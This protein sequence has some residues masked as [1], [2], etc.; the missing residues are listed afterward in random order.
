M[1]DYRAPIDFF[2]KYSEYGGKPDIS[3]T[4]VRATPGELRRLAIAIIS[5]ASARRARRRLYTRR[6]RLRT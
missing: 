2:S 1:A 4:A 5:R 6:R 3:L